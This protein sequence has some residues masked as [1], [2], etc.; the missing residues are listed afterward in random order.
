MIVWFIIIAY[1]I[2][3]VFQI[4][5][6]GDVKDIRQDESGVIKDIGMSITPT[7]GGEYILNVLP[8]VV[9]LSYIIAILESIF[10]IGVLL[11]LEP[12]LR[13]I[14]T[15]LLL[16]A[17]MIIEV[18]GIISEGIYNR[19]RRVSAMS[20][21]EVAG[22]WMIFASFAGELGTGSILAIIGGSI[23]YF[24]PISVFMWGGMTPDV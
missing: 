16:A 24:V 5:I 15:T 4:L 21:K 11:Y 18:D 22:L 8:R 19:Q 10:V 13:V 12:S 1:F 3:H 7:D 17:W 23:L 20:R 2:H 9:A 14:I 6:S